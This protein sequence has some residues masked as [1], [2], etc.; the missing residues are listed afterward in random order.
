[1]NYF[2][3]TYA[4][5]L[6]PTS[7]FVDGVTYSCRDMTRPHT[8]WIDKYRRRN[9]EVIIAGGVPSVKVAEELGAWE[10]F[11]G[12]ELTWVLPFTRGWYLPPCPP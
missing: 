11:V 3:G 2:T 5:S 9:F 10:R 8:N 12:D 7:T 4:V 6:F 1:M